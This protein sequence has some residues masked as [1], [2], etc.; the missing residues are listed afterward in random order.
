MHAF[1]GR[2]VG[3][4]GAEGGAAQV[5]A[6]LEIAGEGVSALLRRWPERLP[7]LRVIGASP[8]PAV[9]RRGVWE[10]VLAAPSAQRE[11]RAAA[12]ANRLSVVSG[13]DVEIAKAV[14]V[15]LD[16]E[17]EAGDHTDLAMPIKSLVSFLDTRHPGPVGPPPAPTPHP[18]GAPP[19][20][21]PHPAA[22]G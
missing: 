13:K 19:A 6:A 8:L 5:A 2:A 17:M 12:E 14:R 7:Q 3:A 16:T 21:S 1:R 11:Y 4:G 9:L 10:L 20:P 15:L 22:L 18:H